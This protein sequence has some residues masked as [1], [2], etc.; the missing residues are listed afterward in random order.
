MTMYAAAP[1]ARSPE[2]R[3]RKIASFGRDRAACPHLEG[4]HSYVESRLAIAESGWSFHRGL[5]VVLVPIT[6]HD[7]SSL[8]QCS[9][10]HIVGQKRLRLCRSAPLVDFETPSGSR[11]MPAG[12]RLE[13]FLQVPRPTRPERR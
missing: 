7:A 11:W 5:A 2:A 1:E 9:W 3:S 13:V 8:P 10:V 12:F 6:S 4:P